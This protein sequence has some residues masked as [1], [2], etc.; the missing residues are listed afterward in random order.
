[1]SATSLCSSTAAL[2][3]ELPWSGPEP[4]R[5]KRTFPLVLTTY[6]NGLRANIV[7]DE[8][9]KLA[10]AVAGGHPNKASRNDGFHVPRHTFASIILEAGESVVMLAR[11]LGHSSPTITLDRYAHFVSEA[12]G[13]GRAAVDALLGVG[14][15]CIPDNLAS[16]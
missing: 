14:P 12:G 7:N 15:E 3:V 4:E 1:M 8:V 16:V 5:E 11:W 10:L 6:G 9:W 13:K 2:Q